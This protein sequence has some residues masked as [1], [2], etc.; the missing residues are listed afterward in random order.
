[1]DACD[2]AI[3]QSLGLEGG[4]SDNPAD[5]GGRTNCGITEKTFQDALRRGIISG[6][7]DISKITKAQITAIYKTDYWNA[8][9]LNDIRD[10]DIAAE[11]FDTAVNSGTG[12]AA[13]LAQLAL[14]YLG[15]R[16]QTDGVMG[17][18]TINLLNKWCSKDPR[19]LF[20]ALNGMQFIHYVAI[21]DKS[22][23][24][25]ITKRVKSDASQMAFSRG[26][27]KRIQSYRQ[28]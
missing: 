11:I 4:Y 21:V 18:A 12:K 19:A 5:R 27:T 1:M 15:E 17:P 6:T 16:L 7:D 14:E 9:K 23:I 10:I 28:T 13:L 2:F 24:E 3:N 26:W 22:I 20:V 25:E 8:L